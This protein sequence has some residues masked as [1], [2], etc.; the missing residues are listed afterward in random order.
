MFS[1]TSSVIWLFTHPVVWELYGFLLR[2]QY[3]G[4]H[5]FGMFVFFHTFPLL[6]EFTHPILWESK[7]TNKEYVLQKLRIRTLFMQWRIQQNLTIFH[8]E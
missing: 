8:G 4:T 7:T 2:M 3:L 1:R 6:W 5:N